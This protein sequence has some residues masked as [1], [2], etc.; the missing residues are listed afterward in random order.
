[1]LDEN[2]RHIRINFCLAAVIIVASSAAQGAVLS[3]DLNRI[4]GIIHM[5]VMI[6]MLLLCL[7]ASFSHR[8]HRLYP[9]LALTAVTLC[10]LCV[11]AIQVMAARDGVLILF[12][13]LILTVIFIYF[14]G[15]LIFY[16]ALAANIIISLAYL[17]AGSVAAI[18]GPRV[19]LQHAGDRRR[20]YVLRLGRVYARENQ[21]H[22]ISRGG[23]AA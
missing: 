20:Q 7:G 11:V 2:L 23:A 22:A 10:G 3:R 13:G 8:R 17:A 5:L 21:P 19:R 9:P 1:M 18:A 15:G 6:P 14:M 4:A 16:H 12:P